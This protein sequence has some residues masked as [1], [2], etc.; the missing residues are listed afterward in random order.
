MTDAFSPSVIVGIDGSDTAI[1]ATQWAV[2]EAVARSVPLRLVYVTKPAHPSA[3]DYYADLHHAEAALRAASDVVA[4]TG[5]P[6][7]VETATVAGLPS[8]SLVAESRDAAMLCIGSVGVGR[9]AEA[10]L[11]STAVD[12][13]RHRAVSRRDHPPAR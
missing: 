4:A 12:P 9:Y 8:V 7:K 3:D 11:G 5:Q 1:H 10:I 2:P 6:V 13:R